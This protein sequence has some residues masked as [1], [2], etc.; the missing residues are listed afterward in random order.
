MPVYAGTEIKDGTMSKII[1]AYLQS[2]RQEL[3]GSDPALIQDALS[4]AQ[5]HLRNALDEAQSLDSETNEE[6]MLHAIIDKYGSAEEVA[7]AYKRMDI[8]T[9]AG[10]LGRRPPEHRSLW[11]KF[12]GIFGDIRA[13]GAFLY[14]LLSGLTSFIYGLWA[15]LGGALSFLSLIFIIGIPVTGLFL[16]SLRG[17]GLIEGRITE[18]LLGVRMPRRPVFMEPNLNWRQ[19]YKALVTE[20]YTWRIFTYL[21]IHFP[22]GL[23]F[24]FVSLFLFSL[25]VKTIFYPVWFWLL[26]R[27]LLTL[28][29][30][31]F[32]PV[33][34]FPL[35]VAGGILLLFL[36]LHLSRIA[37]LLCGRFAK[38]MLVRKNAAVISG[39]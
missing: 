2:L 27:P 24:F 38:A 36:T 17:I 10:W 14:I 5:E 37:G 3:K 22:L 30:P 21:I 1:N 19:K 8:I 9:P 35:I 20:S 26:D 15:I 18:A 7:K 29:Q 16:L 32:P 28:G 11:L 25:S 39:E 4:D 33:W 12:F 34:S 23:L 13:W 6:K 31:L